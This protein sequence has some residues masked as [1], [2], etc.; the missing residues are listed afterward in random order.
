MEKRLRDERSLTLASILNN[1]KLIKMK[2]SI[3]L[4]EKAKELLSRKKTFA[5]DN[6]LAMD[7]VQIPNP[8]S[9]YHQNA[10]TCKHSSLHQLLKLN[11]PS[12]W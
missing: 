11:T 4:L 3:K 12:A 1:Q 5:W 7:V 9:W 6:T 8:T 10:Y 2:K